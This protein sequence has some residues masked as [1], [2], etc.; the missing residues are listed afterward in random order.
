MLQQVF[1]TFLAL[2][3]HFNNT[4]NVYHVVR[5]AWAG[6]S[7]NCSWQEPQEPNSSWL[8]ADVPHSHPAQAGKQHKTLG[9][10]LFNGLSDL[11]T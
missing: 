3:K 2:V 8:G 11:G 4:D 9:E 5:G 10:N 1:Q 7:H 6:I